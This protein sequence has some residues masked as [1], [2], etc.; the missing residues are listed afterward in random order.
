[1]AMASD[2]TDLSQPSPASDTSSY[3]SDLLNP[4]IS[5]AT[6]TA[7]DT[8]AQ[9]GASSD[10]GTFL[11]DPSMPA[12]ATSNQNQTSQTSKASAN[13]DVNLLDDSGSSGP[14]IHGFAADTFSTDYI[15]PRGLVVADKSVVMQPIVGL[16]FPI[17]DI[18]PL[19]NFTVVGG[20][21]NCVTWV[22]NN[23]TVGP[24]NEMDDF[25]SVSADLTDQLNATL[26]YVAFNS[27]TGAYVTE[28]NADLKLVYNDSSFWGNNFSINP[29]ADIWWAIA[30]SSTVVLGKPG[31][32]GYLELGIAPSFTLNNIPD[33]PITLK[34]P[35]YISVGPKDY[36]AYHGSPAT[37]TWGD[38]NVGVFSTSVTASVPLTF[39][40]TKYGYWHLD[41]GLTYFDLINTSLLD[42]GTLASGNTR[43]DLFM[44]YTT[45][46]VKF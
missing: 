21:W 19:K 1:M 5:A 39:M 27:P 22:Q 11:K 29:Y 12:V 17:G 37:G 46:G 34:F 13:S 35:T 7:A 2:P 15:T 16:V 38:G 31:E 3:C 10:V 9:P 30:G 40:G 43:R 44:A 20:L 32:T 42:G 25:F 24:W 45:I 14:N 36:W 26:T 23:G 28:H 41:A 33:Y 18:G 4:Q 6:P 8:P